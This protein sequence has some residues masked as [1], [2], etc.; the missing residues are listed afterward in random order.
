MAQLRRTKAGEYRIEDSV[1]LARLLEEAERGKDVERYL[2]SVDSMFAGLPK[3]VLTENQ[4]KRCR[5]GNPFTYPAPDGR[6]R[7]Y[8]KSGEFLALAQVQGDVMSTVKSFFEV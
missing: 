5:N 7:L 4:E 6:Y 8:S 1:P 3:L 2:K